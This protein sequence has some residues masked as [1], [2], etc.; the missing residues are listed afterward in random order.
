MKKG[1]DDFFIVDGG[2]E[3]RMGVSTGKQTEDDE[4]A[5]QLKN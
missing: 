2:D 4:L 5:E 1:R 3:E